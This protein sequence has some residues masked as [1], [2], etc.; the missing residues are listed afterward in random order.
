MS[1]AIQALTIENA[2]GVTE[3]RLTDTGIEIYAEDTEI[4]ST[5]TYTLEQAE[6]IM[7]GLGRLIWQARHPED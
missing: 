7:A 2:D 4:G 3:L 5:F 6:E 1:D